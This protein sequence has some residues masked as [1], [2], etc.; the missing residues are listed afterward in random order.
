MTEAEV[1][2]IRL[3]LGRDRAYGGETWPL[4]TAA[5]EAALASPRRRTNQRSPTDKSGGHQSGR[6]I[7]N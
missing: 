6:L 2:A 3:S 1:A 5:P 7:L 4:Q